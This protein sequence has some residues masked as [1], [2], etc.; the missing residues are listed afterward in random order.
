MTKMIIRQE[1]SESITKII[2][3]PR[4]SGANAALHSPCRAECCRIRRSSIANFQDCYDGGDV[5]A[6]D[7]H[8]EVD[9]EVEV[10]A[11]VVV[12][13]VVVV[14]ILLLLRLLLLVPS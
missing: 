10:E 6:D 13:V 9:V 2:G 11:V 4:T 12:V 7:I 1:S 8:V 5:D 3:H 14:V